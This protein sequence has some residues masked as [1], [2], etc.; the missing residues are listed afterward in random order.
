[1]GWAEDLRSQEEEA[2]RK[3][4]LHASASAD[5]DPDTAARVFAAAAKTELPTGVVAA[6]LDNVEK[7][8][9]EKTFDYDQYTDQVNGSPVFN[10]FAAEDPYNYAVLERNRKNLTRLERTL[11]PMFQGWDSGWGMTEM[12]EIRDRQLKG[13]KREGDDKRLK[14]LRTLTAGAGD[15]FGV[16]AW[17]MKAMVMT[18]QQ[19]PIQTWIMGE[20]MDETAAGMATGSAI[21]ASYGAAGGTV[22]LPGG[23][24]AVGAAGG[25]AA[26]ALWGGS[27]GLITGRGMAGIKLETGLAYDQYSELGVD[28]AEARKV[29]RISGTIAGAAESIGLGALTKRLPG[30]RQLQSNAVDRVVGQ[31]FKNNTWKQ[32]VARATLQYGE[33]MATELVTE[34]V[35][36]AT[37]IAGGEYLKGQAREAGDVRAETLPMSPDEFWGSMQDIAVATMYGT[38]I[39]GAAGPMAQM[40]SD[41]R[42]ANQA[43]AQQQYLETLGEAVQDE[44]LRE[45]APEAWQALLD[46]WGANGPVKEFRV[47][48]KGWR[49][50]WQ[51]NEIDP[52]E[53]AAELGL[54]EE[55]MNGDPQ[56]IVIPFDKFIDNIAATEH[57]AALVPD[58][59]VDPE[60][61]TQR[62][63]EAWVAGKD[64]EI[65]RIEK[66][67]K[68]QYDVEVDDQIAKDL[69]EE[70]VAGGY[71]PKAAEI[72]S[73]LHAAIMTN[74]ALKVGMDPLELHN[75]RLKGVQKEIPAS[76]QKGTTDA[77]QDHLID[78]LRNNDF[79]KQR[80]IFGDSLIDMIRESGG[81]LDEGGELSARDFGKQFP[82]VIS[83]QGKSIDALAEIASE[84]GYITDYDET[85]MMDA[86]DRELSGTQVFSRNA[87]VDTQLDE[88]RSLME[89]AA[90][91]LDEEG[92][93]LN[94]MT[95]EE[96]RTA[97]E[98]IK[99]LEQTDLEAY[100]KLLGIAIDHDPTLI[101]QVWKKKP[102][103]S[104]EQDFSSVTFTDKFITTDGKSV[105]AT[106]NAQDSYN[107]A[108]NDRNLLNRLLDCLNG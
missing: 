75:L 25:G 63:A 23:G 52:D 80:E 21:G 13:D 50:Y 5:Y 27:I 18:A 101:T 44:K 76:M 87:E 29:A 57:F 61:M 55:Q 103:I 106:V 53:A 42:A 96:V 82:G 108:V 36:E 43:K 85:Q 34:I 33:G 40:R 107:D 47:D 88:Q 84:Q 51:G 9:K 90:T 45:E 14:E 74:H 10:R 95:N 79:P 66:S 68:A 16:D 72:Q 22:I 104:E 67:I 102:R 48:R 17:Y 56:D 4:R 8:L 105:T 71:S 93:D 20:A 28:D 77:G 73:R 89:Q 70:L 98:G 58:I 100:T 12:A 31:L 11:E 97:I 3:Q 1:M 46:R 7:S 62:D 2:T 32:G 81:I 60:G 94:S 38:M 37:V 26:G 6:D 86:I 24:T 64:D 83:K 15:Y 39:I 54:D 19:V 92:I 69:K 35:Q 91:F 49:S 65:S 78:R 30:F 99:T 41:S 59:R